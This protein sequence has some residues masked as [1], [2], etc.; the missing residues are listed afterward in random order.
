MVTPVLVNP[1][2]NIALSWTAEL[3]LQGVVEDGFHETAH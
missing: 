2:R 1:S 3:R